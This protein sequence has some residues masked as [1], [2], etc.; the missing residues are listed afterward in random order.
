MKALQFTLKLLLVFMILSLVGCATGITAKQCENGCESGLVYYLPAPYLVIEE[1]PGDK[2]N[3]K[4]EYMTDTSREFS[5]QPYQIMASSTSFIEFNSDGTLKKFQLDGDATEIPQA[6][7]EG[8]KEVGLKQLEL[9]KAATDRKL[10]EAKESSAKG[11]N[12]IKG[13]QRHIS[14]YKVEGSS[15]NKLD[16]AG[17]L[18]VPK[19]SKP[20]QTIKG[21][22]DDAKKNIV[23]F[24]VP[25]KLSEVDIDKLVFLKSGNKPVKGT[26]VSAIK[27]KISFQNGD[28]VIPFDVLRSNGIAKITH[29]KHDGEVT[30]SAG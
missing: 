21:K 29:K 2:W 9:E 14:I 20:K 18:A 19:P 13:D 16:I 28:I 1:L 23:I 4:I 11:D 26:T 22:S 30:I 12:G 24:G 10:Q 17:S 27:A 3:A 8:I 15:L 6:V 25:D 7:V 5:V